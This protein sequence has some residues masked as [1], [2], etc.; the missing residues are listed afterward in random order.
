LEST[1]RLWY[2]LIAE[3]IDLDR[4]RLT[5]IRKAT[6]AGLPGAQKQ[7]ATRK[8]VAHLLWHIGTIIQRRHDIVHNCDRP[9]SAKQGL[10]TPAQ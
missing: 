10:T 3:Y 7:P 5:G 8:A 1:G 4:L 6:Y 9:R 2:G